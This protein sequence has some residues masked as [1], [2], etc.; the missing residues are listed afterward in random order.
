MSEITVQGGKM[1]TA[2]TTL[3]NEKWQTI[4]TLNKQIAILES[5]AQTGIKEIAETNE[6]KFYN[7]EEFSSFIKSAEE[8]IKIIN[9]PDYPE[10]DDN[11]IYCQQKLSKS[12]DTL[13]KNYRILLNDKTQENIILLKKEKDTLI[14]AVSLLNAN[15]V[16]HQPTF[17]LSETQE[18]IQPIEILEYNK[19]FVASQIIFTTDKV[20]DGSA[21][22]M[23]YTTYLNFLLEKHASLKVILEQKQSLLKNLA[24]EP[25]ILY[26]EI[27]ELKDV[28]YMPTAIDAFQGFTHSYTTEEKD[29]AKRFFRLTNSLPLKGK[30]P[31]YLLSAY[32][33]LV[34]NLNEK[35]NKRRRKK[36]LIATDLSIKQRA[37]KGESFKDIAD[38]ILDPN[39]EIFPDNTYKDKLKRK[40]QTLK[41][42][43]HRIKRRFSDK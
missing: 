16:F 34:K 2:Q 39:E 33:Q 9:K 11:C 15:L 23:E 40:A 24:I 30:I 20:P 25:Y 12:A 27:L 43:N 31:R 22:D 14:K 28:F 26:G 3:T 10:T 29:A 42:R 41:T 17:G 1:R 21:F 8:Y 18:P 36:T 38:K 35:K 13:L 37:D 32:N 6:I 4:I 5:K 19:K 7:T